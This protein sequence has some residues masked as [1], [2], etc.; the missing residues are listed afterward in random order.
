MIRNL[1]RL[2]FKEYG[3]VAA[4]KSPGNVSPE[5]TKSFTPLALTQ[6]DLQ[7]YL[8]NSEVWL[9][10][11]TGMTVLSVS[12]DAVDFQH[13]Y[14]DKPVC[15]HP[16]IYFCLSPFRRATSGAAICSETPPSPIEHALQ[17]EDLLL[18]NRLKVTNLYTFF[19]TKK[20]KGFSFPA[21]HTPC[22]S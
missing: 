18:Q 11:G 10:Y 22:W 9:N 4:E 6:N 8:A 3:Q 16:G 21:K 5:K 1:N 20:K 12:K 2:N 7:V 14:L 13:Y 19:T 15:I 17:I